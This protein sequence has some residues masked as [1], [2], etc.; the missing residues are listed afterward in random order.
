MSAVKSGC[1]QKG[2]PEYCYLNC[3]VYRYEQVKEQSTCIILLKSDRLLVLDIAH[4]GHLGIIKIK[5]LL[6][7][8]LWFPCMDK[9]V[10]TKIKDCMFT[11]SSC[12]PNVHQRTTS[13]G[14]QQ[15]FRWREVDSAHVD[16]ETLLLVID[17]YS[18]FPFVEPVSSPSARAVIP[19]EDQHLLR[20]E[21][22]FSKV[23]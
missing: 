20:W 15:P 1:C 10:E 8:K 3:H 14:Y 6:R 19:K 13:N 2:L 7:K 4:K 11:V 12:Y 9:I 22:P 18:L 16:G 21:L 23:R 17:D 5:A